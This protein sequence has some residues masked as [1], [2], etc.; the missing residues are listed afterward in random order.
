MSSQPFSSRSRVNS[1]RGKVPVSPAAGASIVPRAT[2]TVSSSDGSCSTASSRAR[3]NS[4]LDLG[5]EEALLGAVVAEDVAESGRD[6]HFEAV[7][8]QRPDG[9]L[10][11]RPDAEV[12]PGHEDGGA[13]VLAAG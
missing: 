5:R 2:S 13:G 10:A 3:P 7:V 8:D 4:W 11:R 9:V 12:G 6:D 1:S